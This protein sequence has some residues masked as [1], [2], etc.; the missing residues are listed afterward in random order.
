MAEKK[1]NIKKKNE[2]P[3]KPCWQLK[4][5]SYSKDEPLF[6]FNNLNKKISQKDFTCKNDI[7]KKNFDNKDNSQSLKNSL[8][9]SKAQT[10]SREI[11]NKRYD[12][13][14]NLITKGG[15]QRITFIDKISNANFVEVIKVENYK[16]YN[17]MEEITPNN[18]NGCCLLI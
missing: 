4:N 18:G 2:S 15:K 10:K 6:G 14:G 1:I 8:V 17:K 13:S 11:D 16:E 9:F 12:T 5:E 7:L 3:D